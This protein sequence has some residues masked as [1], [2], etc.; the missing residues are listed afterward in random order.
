[1]DKEGS[2]GVLME[3]GSSVFGCKSEMT[4]VQPG[5]QISSWTYRTRV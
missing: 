2:Q 3:I 4:L 1:M 5:Y